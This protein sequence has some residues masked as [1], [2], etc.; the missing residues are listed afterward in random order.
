MIKRHILYIICLFLLTDAAAQSKR[1]FLEAANAAY[2]AKNYYAALKFYNEV[3]AFD[4]TDADIIFKAAESARYFDSYKL[5][6]KKYDYL[7]DTAQYF[8]DS[9]IYFYAAE[10]HQR[11][12]DYDKANEYFDLYLTQYG[13]DGDVLTDKAKQGKKSVLWASTRLNE[14]DENVALTQLDVNTE[15]NDFAASYNGD[16]LFYSSHKFQEEKPYIKKPAQ[17]LSKLLVKEKDEIKEL[18][19]GS[20]EKNKSIANLSFNSD[21]SR[22]YFTVCEYKDDATLRCDLFWSPLNADGTFDVEQKVASPI[23]LDGFTTTQPSFALD[24]TSGIETLYFVSD[25]PGGKGKLDIW[26]AVYD[27]KLGFSNPI[28]L[29]KI[30]TPENEVTPFFHIPTSKLYFST[31]GRQGYGGYDIYSTPLDIAENADIEPMPLP[32]NSSYHDLYYT[33]DNDGKKALFSSNREGAAYV[34]ILLE[35]CCFDIFSADITPVEIMLHASTFDKLLN[36]PLNDVTVKLIDAKTGAIVAEG[37][38]LAK[39]EYKFPLEKD[40]EYILIGNKEGYKGD[41][42]KFNTHGIKKSQV[43]EKT[44]NLEASEL[45]L[46]AFTF[47]AN[48]KEKLNGAKV[49]IEDLTDP[50]NPVLVQ[51]NELGNNFNFKLKPNRTYRVTASKNGYASVSETIDTRGLTGKISKNLFLPRAD[52][53]RLLPLALFFDNDDPN[54]DT[55]T[56]ETT[57]IYGDLVKEYMIRKPVFLERYTRGVNGQEKDD[58]KQRMEEFFEGEVR[59]GYDR[60]SIFM[61]EL[62]KALNQGQ[63]IE[64]TIR[65]YASPRFEPRYNLVLGQRRINSVRNDMMRYA[66]QAI[67]PYLVSRQLTITEISYGEELSPI[68]V[69]DN[70]NDE[71]GSIYSLKASKERKVEVIS[72]KI[73]S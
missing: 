13:K 61:E 47:D 24:P 3:L 56:T 62:L 31:D 46:E 33:L 22:A 68:D 70:I 60:F 12:G 39:H 50:E 19:L 40:K 29:D 2:E 5:A 6:A 37:R 72:V 73:K 64:M 48:N 16:N 44:L 66:N 53:N 63:K 58:S 67:A 69:E 45:L 14:K 18:S 35:S 57:A 43:I 49:M 59:G 26:Y 54:P 21:K 52:I 38:E 15:F 7:I 42:V 1:A 27:K 55:K 17:R 36:Q 20:T 30:N 32:T 51:V 23:N 11:I 9:T 25:R 34:D 65:G 28:N 4:E 41:T 71:R 8:N 10:M